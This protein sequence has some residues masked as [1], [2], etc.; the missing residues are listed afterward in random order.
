LWLG[1]RWAGSDW[2]LDLVG[3]M[4][5]DIECMR[6]LVVVEYMYSPVVVE[7]TRPLTLYS[8]WKW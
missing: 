2:D 6:L 8:W 3:S 5:V 1:W 7:C 4:L